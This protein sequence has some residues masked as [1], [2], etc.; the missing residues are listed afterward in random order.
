MPTAKM[1]FE[2]LWF[3]RSGVTRLMPSRPASMSSF[4]NVS[5][6]IPLFSD[7]YDVPMR[8]CQEEC[9]GMTAAKER[10]LRS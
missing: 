1:R 8:V 4:R 6:V 7:V 5:V 9:R 10:A 2:G 3:G